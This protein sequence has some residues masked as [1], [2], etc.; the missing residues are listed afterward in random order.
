MDEN[1][2]ITQFLQRLGLEVS[3]TNYQWTQYWI[4]AEGPYGTQ[5]NPLNILDPNYTGGYDPNAA[6]DW[7]KANSGPACANLGTYAANVIAFLTGQPSNLTQSLS[8]FSGHAGQPVSPTVSTFY[9]NP[10]GAIGKVAPGANVEQGSLTPGADVSGSALAVGVAGPLGW[11]LTQGG[12][13]CN[14]WNPTSWGT[15]INAIEE[16]TLL[17]IGAISLVFVGGIWIIFGNNA[18]KKI[19]VGKMKDALV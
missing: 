6:A 2:W 15:C 8:C 14:M 11:I 13:G 4:A 7:L 17:M 19:F 16:S 5:K 9:A 10:G 1:S 18:T 3:N 12:P